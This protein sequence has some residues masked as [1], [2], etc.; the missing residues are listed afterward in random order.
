MVVPTR[1]HGLINQPQIGFVDQGGCLERLARLL[2]GE[3]GRGELAELGVYEREELLGG[4]AVASLNG[5]KDMG[6]VGNWRAF[7]EEECR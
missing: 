7:S 3:L 6:D 2:M 4:L 1:R 5:R